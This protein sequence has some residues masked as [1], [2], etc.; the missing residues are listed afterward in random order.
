MQA[1]DEKTYCFEGYA[2]D[3]RRGCLRCED[4]DVELR[5]KSFEVLRFCWRMLAG[6]WRRTS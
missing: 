1:V 3:L 2:L 5:P 4:R 6:W